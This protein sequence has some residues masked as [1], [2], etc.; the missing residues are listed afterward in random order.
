MRPGD[1]DEVG[2]PV[3]KTVGWS[4]LLMRGGALGGDEEGDSVAACDG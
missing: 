2:L 1:G 3:G 4:V